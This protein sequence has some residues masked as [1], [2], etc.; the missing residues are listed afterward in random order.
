MSP[1]RSNRGAKAAP[2][3]AA[4]KSRTATPRAKGPA[5]QW[6]EYHT[7]LA[8]SLGAIIVGALMLVLVLNKYDFDTAAKGGAAL[9][10]SA[11]TRTLA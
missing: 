11:V 3:K 8:V 6:D 1:P 7:L 10:Q 2:A 5:G 4:K 9:D